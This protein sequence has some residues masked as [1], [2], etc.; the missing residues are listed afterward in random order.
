[1]ERLAHLY[2]RLWVSQLIYTVPVGLL[3]SDKRFINGIVA[4]H[5]SQAATETKKQLCQVETYLGRNRNDPLSKVK[6][7]VLDLD[8][9]FNGSPEKARSFRSNEPY[10]KACNQALQGEQA[11]YN[12]DIVLNLNGLPFGQ[13]PATIYL[14]GGTS[15]IRVQHQEFNGFI[16]RTIST[17]DVE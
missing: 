16:D 2:E 3:S 13:R 7:R 9:L 10:L 4:F 6:D 8:I 12:T 5:T 14:D 1:M 11:D 15:H 17:F